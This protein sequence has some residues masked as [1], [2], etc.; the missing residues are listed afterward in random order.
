MRSTIGFGHLKSEVV[1]FLVSVLF[2]GGM[3]DSWIEWFN[4]APA[5]ENQLDALRRNAREAPVPAQ[6]EQPEPEGPAAEGESAEARSWE[7]HSGN[8][9]CWGSMESFEAH[10]VL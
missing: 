6:A 1:Y 10:L 2:L 8:F 4:G 7:G 3:F 5:L 9:F